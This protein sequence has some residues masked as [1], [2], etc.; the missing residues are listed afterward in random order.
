MQ[1]VQAGQICSL[2]IKPG[3]SA[4]EWLKSGGQ[5]RRGMV[6]INGYKPYKATR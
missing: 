3:V 2:S 1:S 5:I 6:L 4:D